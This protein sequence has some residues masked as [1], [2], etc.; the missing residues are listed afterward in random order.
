[1]LN[2]WAINHVSSSYANSE[3]CSFKL[4]I[5]NKMSMLCL[6]KSSIGEEEHYLIH[7]DGA[8]VSQKQWGLLKEPP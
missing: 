1:M 6:L 7:Y 3:R 5:S 2:A 4:N 8:F